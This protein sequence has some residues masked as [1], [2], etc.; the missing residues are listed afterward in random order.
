MTIKEEDSYHT[1]VQNPSPDKFLDSPTPQRRVSMG[2]DQKMVRGSKE[3]EPL[4]MS[5]GGSP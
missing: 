4:R 1:L 2:K 5:A 3:I